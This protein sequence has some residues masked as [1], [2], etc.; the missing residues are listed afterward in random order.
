MDNIYQKTMQ[1]K[2]NSKKKLL[3]M[4][5]YILNLL[6]LLLFFFNLQIPYFDDSRAIIFMVAISSYDQ[7]LV[8]DSTIK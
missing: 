2:K 4:N 8:E 5:A 1:N 3:Y 7:M 6:L